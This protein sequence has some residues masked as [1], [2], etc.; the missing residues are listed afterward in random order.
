MTVGVFLGANNPGLADDSTA[1]PD[2]VIILDPVT[3]GTKTV[4]WSVPP[5]TS[6]ASWVD[7][8]SYEDA[9]NEYLYPGAALIVR[10]FSE[11]GLDFTSSGEVKTGK[12]QVDLFLGDNLV[13]FPYAVGNTF[14]GSEIATQLQTDESPSPDEVILLAEDQGSTTFVS[15]DTDLGPGVSLQMVEF[16]NY[17]EEGTR[18]IVEGSGLLIRR[19]GGADGVITFPAQEIAP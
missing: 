19:T 16:V 15:S 14:D 17:T 18:I 1:N 12:T 3:Q 9:S 13:T 2:Q 7:F 4:V 10:R 11:D 6:P 5:N 8:V